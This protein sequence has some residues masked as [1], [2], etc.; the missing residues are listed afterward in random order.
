M[1]ANHKELICIFKEFLSVEAYLR[2]QI[3]TAVDT[4]YI[5]ALQYFN[6]KSTKKNIYVIIYH[7]F[8]I[9]VEITPQ[10][11]TQRED[12]VK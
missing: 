2:Q 8:D 5:S 9:Y 10:M 1:Q 3:L 4:K 7:I 11:F 6:T 12:V